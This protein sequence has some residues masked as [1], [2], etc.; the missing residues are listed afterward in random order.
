M[1][2]SPA[3]ATITLHRRLERRDNA[4]PEVLMDYCFVRRKDEEDV[5]SIL[6]LKDRLSQ[7]ILALVVPSRG[8]AAAARAEN[9]HQ[10][11][12]RI[13]PIERTLKWTELPSFAGAFGTSL[14]SRRSDRL[15][16]LFSR[17]HGM[18]SPCCQR[19]HAL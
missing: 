8:V 10:G 1:R 11:D 5:T 18:G 7:A 13:L 16:H 2:V 9:R 6:V 15:A 12:D 4:V 19:I 3:A 17:G 14:L